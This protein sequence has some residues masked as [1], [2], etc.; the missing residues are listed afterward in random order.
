MVRQVGQGRFWRS[1]AIADGRARMTDH[2]RGHAEL[3][4]LLFS[5]GDFMEMKVRQ[6]A[7]MDRKERRRQVTDQASAKI[8]CD[9]G[10]SPEMCLDLGDVERPEKAQTLD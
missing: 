6:V 4:D 8:L 10:R 5:I 3:T 1:D 9:A 2:H 7:Q